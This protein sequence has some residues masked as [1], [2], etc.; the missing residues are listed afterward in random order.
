MDAERSTWNI[1]APAGWRQ[2][3][4]RP[5]ERAQ[6]HPPP[7]S[8]RAQHGGSSSYPTPL[9]AR[10]S[11][12]CPPPDRLDTH[13]RPRLLVRCEHTGRPRVALRRPGAFHW[14]GGTAGASD[15]AAVDPS[16]DDP[17][18]QRVVFHVEQGRAPAAHREPVFHVEHANRRATQGCSPG[19]QAARPCPHPP[20][21]SRTDTGKA[22]V[23]GAGLSLCRPGPDVG[24]QRAT[25]SPSG[26]PSSIGSRA[27]L[28]P[29]HQ[30][31]R[32][33]HRAGAPAS[34]SRAHDAA[35]TPPQQPPERR[36]RSVASRCF[37]GQ[38]GGPCTTTTWAP[39]SRGGRAVPTERAL[40]I[41]SGQ[42]LR[43]EPRRCLVDARGQAGGLFH[44]EQPF[45]RGSRPASSAPTSRPTVRTAVAW[46]ARRRDAGTDRGTDG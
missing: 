19:N 43:I 14:P 37:H 40:S 36:G 13:A 18:G 34:S 46:R 25:T 35:F 38:L 31:S 6:Y 29:G 4:P 15:P 10:R 2:D 45:R 26:S 23:A 30:C 28:R 1:G 33:P 11:C 20:T 44:V 8:S 22:A 5:R 27:A 21:T 24:L 32:R 3:T 42:L 17:G 12:T 16:P 9:A 41:E 39:G 7:R